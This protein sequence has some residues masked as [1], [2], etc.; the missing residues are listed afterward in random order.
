MKLPE[1]VAFIVKNNLLL[2]NFIDINHNKFINLVSI[3]ANMRPS[4]S[5]I[6]R[7]SA[8]KRPKLSLISRL[9]PWLILNTV[10]QLILLDTVLELMTVT[11]I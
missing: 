9:N 3:S 2:L 11:T 10:L 4:L 1:I 5:L 8:N 6:A 7:L